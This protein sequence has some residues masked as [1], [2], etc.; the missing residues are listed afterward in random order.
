MQQER[1]T[2]HETL[3]R[4]G[5][6]DAAA[7]AQARAHLD[8]L[9]KPP[10]SL[11]MLEEIAIRLAGITGQPRPEYGGGVVIVMAG[12]H[13]VVAEGVAAYPPEVTV[14]ML[15]NF[16]RGGAAINVLARQAGARVVLVDM[17]V[18][19][20]VPWP[21][22]IGRKIRPGAGNIAQGPAMSREEAMR[23]VEAG[24]EV[25]SSQIGEAKGGGFTVLATGE[26]GIGN[27]TPSSAILAAFSGFPCERLVGP[28]TGLVA[29]KVRHKAEVV[30]RALA[31]NHPDPRDP[32]DVLAKVGGLEIGGLAG[33]ILA[34]AASRTPVVIDGF[35]SG[36]AALIAARLSPAAA[37]YILP[38]HESA[39]PGHALLLEM[40]GLRAMLR[41]DMRLGEGTGAALALHLVKAAT[42]V[43]A[44]MATFAEAGVSGAGGGE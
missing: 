7:M 31:V 41:L 25:A 32:L 5:G 44:E 10:G 17:G 15:G 21:E 2:L 20:E 16:V 12:D 39:E 19:G 38:S 34:A 14:Q 22:V 1:F 40:L 23:A 35:I 24:I 4:I 6:L 27:T 29:E 26:M 9:T 30:R 18:A 3:A 13:G 11:G 33:C 37:A 8:N 42:L 28:G 43:A 36:T